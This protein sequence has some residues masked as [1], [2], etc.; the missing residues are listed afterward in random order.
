MNKERMMTKEENDRRTY[1]LMMARKKANEG[2]PEKALPK[3]GKNT[4]KLSITPTPKHL[5]NGLGNV[6]HKPTMTVPGKR[7][8]KKKG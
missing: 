2:K 3:T 1:E 7:G 5:G 4:P 8:S 6:K